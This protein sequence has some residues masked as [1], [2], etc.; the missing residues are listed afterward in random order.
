MREWASERLTFLL[1]VALP[2]LESLKSNKLV[3]WPISQKV[4][5]MKL[6]LFNQSHCKYLSPFYNHIPHRQSILS[7]ILFCRLKWPSRRYDTWLFISSNIF[8]V[9]TLVLN[10]FL[11]MLGQ[12]QI[13]GENFKLIGHVTSLIPNSDSSCSNKM[14]WTIFIIAKYNAFHFHFDSLE[15]ILT[16]LDDFLS[17]FYISMWLDLSTVSV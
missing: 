3:M 17:H 11:W 12:P 16:N 15:I 2:L 9:D 5:S 4:S 1:G 8:A 10:P 6:Q 7:Q 14:K 13:N